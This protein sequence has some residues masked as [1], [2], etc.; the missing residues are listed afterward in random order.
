M[1]STDR[2]VGSRDTND[3]ETLEGE[4]A[5]CN[6]SNSSRGTGISKLSVSLSSSPSPNGQ[7]N[8]VEL[9][10]N[11]TSVQGGIQTNVQVAESSP[12]SDGSVKFS[13]KFLCN[14]TNNDQNPV[15]NSSR[16]YNIENHQV[17]TKNQV[18]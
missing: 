5:D 12:S 4:A 9:N 7:Q 15:H 1:Q 17:R 16:G 6:S 14:V 3:K 13:L 18:L 10:V 11:G 2:T 8:L